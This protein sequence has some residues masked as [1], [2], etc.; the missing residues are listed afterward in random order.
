MDEER[1]VELLKEKSLV[2]CSIS[3]VVRELNISRSLVR[4]LLA[5]LE[6]AGHVSY[7]NV[8]MAKL[9]I[10]TDGI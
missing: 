5:K 7:R 2:G 6:G 4:T 1:I 3:D 9:Y 10:L 8:G